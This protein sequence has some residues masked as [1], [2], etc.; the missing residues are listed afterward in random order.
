MEGDARPDSLEA[1]N[2]L[3]SFAQSHGLM[4]EE[5]GQFVL[6]HERDGDVNTMR[7]LNQRLKDINIFGVEFRILGNIMFRM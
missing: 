6:I 5:S 3:V 2:A 4:V 7:T 1:F